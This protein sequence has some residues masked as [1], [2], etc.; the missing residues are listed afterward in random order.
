MNG[1]LD[2]QQEGCKIT[3]KLEL[4]LGSFELK[5]SV[6]GAKVAFDIELPQGA[7]TEKFAGQI[8]G[9]KLTGTTDPH[10][11]KWEASHGLVGTL[12]EFR[13]HPAAFGLKPDSGAAVYFQV[14]PE[15]QVVRVP[16]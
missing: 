15:T 6:D 13:S 1:T 11:F 4:P 2:F 5:G 9:A 14:S 16:P 3:G 8:D 10:G 7:G 12:I